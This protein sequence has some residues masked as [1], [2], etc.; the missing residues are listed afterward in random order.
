MKAIVDTLSLTRDLDDDN[1]Q[2][3]I[4]TTDD[5]IIRYLRHKATLVATKHF[6]K[7]IFVRG[8]IEIS[9]H[10][11][12]NCYYCG[13][14]H[15]NHNI[16]R[17]R[18]SDNE[19]LNCCIK[20]YM[21][22]LRTFVLQAGEDMALS[23]KRLEL[24]IGMII[25]ACPEAAVTL[26]LGERSTQ[27]YQ[28]LYN[29][30]ASR[31]LL[32]HEAADSH[33]YASLHPVSMSHDNRIKCLQSLIGIGYQTGMGMMAGV[34]G[35][36]TRHL[37]ADLRLMQK[38]NPQMIGIGPFLPQSDTPLGNNQPG[39]MSLTLKL[40][41]IAR[42]MHPNALIPATTALASLHENGRSLG[43][44][45]GANVVMPNLSPVDIRDKYAIYDNKACRH[46]ESAEGLLQ[47]EQE[48]NRIGYHINYSRG[49]Y[50]DNNSI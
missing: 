23:D 24:L 18:L 30:G 10:C 33:L 25:Q 42:L 29:A 26:S 41:A 3:L 19:I 15:D 39:S 40:T 20:G 31:Y 8:L 1:F 16:Q 45:S 35:Q 27:S 49:D 13:L 36:T 7:G 11:R 5:E 47:L 28:R 12:N 22:G 9:N 32:R 46:A 17:Y 6:G 44:L 34:S 37:I 14:R 4:E 2:A 50:H 21:L 48:L 43:I 38:L